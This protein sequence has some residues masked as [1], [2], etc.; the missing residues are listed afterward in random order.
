MKLISFGEIIWDVFPSGAT[1]GGAPL[2]LAAHAAL[3]GA[4]VNILSAVGN[5]ALGAR[6]LEEIK[7]LGIS[8]DQIT[9]TEKAPSGR[10]TVTLDAGG[11]PSY[12]IAKISAYDFISPVEN[13]RADVICFGTLALRYMSNIEALKKI[14]DSGSFGE[15]FTDLNIRPPFYSQES[16]DFC[17][18]RATV[19]KM[20]DVDMQYVM[21]L[22][23]EET[24]EARDF[25]RLIAR[26]YTQIRLIILTLGELGS[27]CYDTKAD[28]FYECGIE[29]AEVV[30]TV[31]AGDSFGATFLVEYMKTKSIE[32]SMKRA[33]KVSAFVVSRQGAIP[34][35]IKDFLKEVDER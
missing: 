26:R 20:S 14:L 11:V 28:A 7:S 10:C 12:E 22:L 17:L 3:Q 8:T 13:M 5:D 23:S 21:E 35:D 24:C 25:I 19:V 34:S 2:N 27:L 30:S 15:I 16:V 9:L 31:G 29:K 1:L 33:A 18:S 32:H 4:E 6:S